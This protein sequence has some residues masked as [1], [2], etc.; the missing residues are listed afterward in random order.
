MIYPYKKSNLAR[1]LRGCSLLL[2]LLLCACGPAIPPDAAPTTP[3][4]QSPMPT[5]Q[6]A[7]AV[8]FW[9]QFQGML[10]CLPADGA[11][12]TGEGALPWLWRLGFSYARENG[13][14]LERGSGPGELWA[15]PLGYL[16]HM[17]W[18]TYGVEGLDLAGCQSANYLGGYSI[19]ASEIFWLPEPEPEE[20]APYDAANS[21]VEFTE[22]TARARVLLAGQNGYEA[23]LYE[24][25]C[26]EENGREYYRFLSSAPEE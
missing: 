21:T 11:Q 20:K 2:A 5:Q 9:Q 3:P 26:V 12:P 22:Q 25:A 16:Q 19:A 4:A 14:E 24:F 1:Y 17:A 18:L 15:F 7:R 6:E 13:I 23:R 10:P 8:R